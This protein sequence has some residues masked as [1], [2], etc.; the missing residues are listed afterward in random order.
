MRA[1]EQYAGRE[2]T[3]M[4][5]AQDSRM[6]AEDP[7][8]PCLLPRNVID[9]DWPRASSYEMSIEPDLFNGVQKQ[10]AQDTSDFKKAFKPGK[11]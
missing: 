10:I 6:I 1:K 4:S 9:R 3:R 2:E 8:A 11:Y 5:M 7:N